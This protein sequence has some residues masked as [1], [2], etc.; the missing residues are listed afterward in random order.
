MTKK[1][2][3]IVLWGS[4]LFYFLSLTIYSIFSYSLTA[5]NLVLSSN[6]TFWKFQT[7]MWTTFFNNRE[8]LSQTYFTLMSITFISYFFFVSQAIKNKINNFKLIL[9]LLL[10]LIAPLLIS[11]NALSYDAFNYIFNAK[12]VSV[13]H[14]DP[15]VKTALDF[16]DDPWT[17]FMHNIHTPAPYGKAWTYL[18]LIP[19]SLGMGK[20]ILT[21]LSFRL[22]SLLPLLTLLFIYWKYKNKIN[23][24]WAL[25]LI[26]NP[27]VLIEVIS[28]FHNDFWM[29]TP[30]ILSLLLIDRSEK[31]GKLINLS[32]ILK[33]IL[34]IILLGLSIW[35]KLATILLIPIW[36]L[37]LIKNRLEEIPH[38]YSL[39][40]HWPILASL[41]MF[42]PL[43]TS[44][45]QWF[46]PW[47]LIWTIS[48]IPLFT[49]NNKIA[50]A[51][52]TA[53]LILSISSMYR[54]LPFLWNNNYE[55][56]VLYWQ[57]IIS[58]IPFVIALLFSMRSIFNK[59]K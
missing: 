5:P 35:V 33:V 6:P 10:T 48:F 20:F 14:V 54:Y 31:K 30:A 26:F 1:S 3:K 43:L 44:R 59:K 7:Y 46:H 53:L 57:R 9:I 2:S 45:S 34:S 58:F 11:N 47:Y 36:L 24:P 8:L 17:K 50:K 27:L 42:L 16:S 15:H 29:V 40:N 23:Y 21:W 13:Y 32:F 56:N 25:L 52:T 12:M 41:L 51:W 19:F 4:F 39:A 38:F 37:I 18:S 22:F 55:G 49:K 28:N